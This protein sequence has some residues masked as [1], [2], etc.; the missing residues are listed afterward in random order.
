MCFCW[1]LLYNY[2]TVQGCKIIKFTN[3]NIARRKMLTDVNDEEISNGVVRYLDKVQCK[4]FNNK[5]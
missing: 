3:K 1:V 2:I 4:W 5:K